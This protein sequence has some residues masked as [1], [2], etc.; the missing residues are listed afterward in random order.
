VLT[1]SALRRAARDRTDDCEQRSALVLAPHPDDETLGCGAT[2]MRKLAAGRQVTVAVATDGRYSHRS[3]H[4]TPEQLADL[5]RVEMEEAGR[6]LGLSTGDIR[7]GGFVDGSLKDHLDS[8]TK[9]IAQMLEEL[10]PDEVYTTSA[11]ET[12]PDHA[13]LG[14]AARSAVGAYDGDCLLLEYPVWLWQSWPVQRGNRLG[15]TATAA[16]MVLGRRAIRVRSDGYL[17]GKLHAL[18]AHASQLG[19]LEGMPDEEAWEALPP[20]IL[21]AAAAPHE[22]FLPWRRSGNAGMKAPRTSD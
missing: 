7:W 20:R 15:S 10:A 19:G 12:H 21:A 18:Q 17:P 5:R 8:L 16:G 11:D 14:R 3:N 1:V 2:I 22:L 6:R 9:F 13:T 4:V